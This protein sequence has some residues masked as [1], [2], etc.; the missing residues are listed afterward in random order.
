MLATSRT[1]SVE[2]VLMM[3][4]FKNTPTR[5]V[6]VK[7]SCQPWVLMEVGKNEGSIRMPWLVL[8]VA[9]TSHVMGVRSTRVKKSRMA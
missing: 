3:K 4:L 7:A 6:F 2:E 8:K 1:E 5:F 9:R